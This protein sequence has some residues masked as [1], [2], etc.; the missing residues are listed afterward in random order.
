M[1]P[2]DALTIEPLRGSFLHQM[3]SPQ[4]LLIDYERGGV[5]LND[6]SQGLSVQLWSTAYEDDVVY[7][8]EESGA[9]HALFS[10]P[11]ITELS[12]AFYQSAAPFVA[13]ADAGGATFW[14]FNPNTA[15]HEFFPYLPPTISGIR[16]TLDD[17]RPLSATTND[18]VVAYLRNGNLCA[19]VQRENFANEKVLAE[20]AGSRLIQ[21]GMNTVLR[22][23]FRARP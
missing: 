3:N 19:R 6:S 18:I 16:C 1:I 4:E 15:Q 8:V 14:W 9:R 17:S 22:L 13:F 12:L 23:Q 7:A 20:N 5:A 21:L 11:G 2:G 10:R